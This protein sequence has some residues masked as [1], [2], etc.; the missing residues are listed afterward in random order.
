MVSIENGSA[1][2]K[3]NAVLDNA[4]ALSGVP[5]DS[6][7]EVQASQEAYEDDLEAA[8][9]WSAT[10]GELGAQRPFG[11]I[12]TDKLVSFREY[13]NET[14]P[15]EDWNL[16]KVMTEL[17]AVPTDDWIYGL[18][19]SR[20]GERDQLRVRSLKLFQSVSE[21]GTDWS[22]SYWCRL[23]FDDEANKI[24]SNPLCSDALSPDEIARTKEIVDIAAIPPRLAVA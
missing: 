4:R 17:H 12:F 15:D 13:L 7:R 10:D 14:R 2:P 18:G 21:S 1:A 11:E 19:Y 5:L 20:L 3:E 22:D 16:T 8:W 9:L 24:L 23:M 6:Y